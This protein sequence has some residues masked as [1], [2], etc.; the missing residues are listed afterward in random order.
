MARLKFQHKS[1]SHTIPC[2]DLTNNTASFGDH[3]NDMNH[4]Y[5]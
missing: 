5:E 4:K 2:H 1:E 3:G